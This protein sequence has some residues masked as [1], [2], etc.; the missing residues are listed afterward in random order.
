MLIGIRELNT[1]IKFLFA[2]LLLLQ[3]GVGQIKRP[4]QL[5][6]SVAKYGTTFQAMLY[7]SDE[8]ILQGLKRKLLQKID[9]LEIIFSTYLEES[10]LNQ[11]TKYPACQ[12]IKLSPDLYHCIQIAQQVHRE[13]QGLFDPSIGNWTDH[14][15]KA[16]GDL[17]LPFHQEFKKV[18]FLSLTLHEQQEVKFDKSIFK[19]DL[20]GIAKGYV[21]DSLA[22]ILKKHECKRFFLSLGGEII[23]GAPPP[24]MS[25]W[26]IACEGPDRQVVTYLELSEMAL[27]SSGSSYQFIWR[28]GKKF[29][30]LYQPLQKRASHHPEI[31]YVMAP[32]SCYADAWATAVQINGCSN[33]LKGIAEIEWGGLLS[34]QG[35]QD[36]TGELP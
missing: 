2:T 36:T 29:S 10:E 24:N 30:H 11:M 18:D 16:R 13:S 21:L 1:T 23:V 33:I 22:D 34:H 3:S 12:P 15:K 35:W 14:W 5:Q 6:I 32:K 31:A 8:R 28:D 27:S 7:H 25:H 9:Q 17:S 20:G 19:I 4:A 26:R